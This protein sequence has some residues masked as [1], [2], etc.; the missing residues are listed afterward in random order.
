MAAGHNPVSGVPDVAVVLD[1]TWNSCFM[2]LTRRRSWDILGLAYQSRDLALAGLLFG[3]R[4]VAQAGVE[5][6]TDVE[7]KLRQDI[8]PASDAVPL[9]GP[10][11][12]DLMRY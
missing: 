10:L 4:V 1:D 9:F 12:S 2:R 6:V 7:S 5:A 11:S 8:T 3:Q